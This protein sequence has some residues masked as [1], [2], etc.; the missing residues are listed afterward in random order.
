MFVALWPLPAAARRLG[1]QAR[2]AASRHGGRA[3]PA[4]DLHV[5]LAF[6]GELA[7]AAAIGLAAR[8]RSG[9]HGACPPPDASMV[10]DRIGSFRGA[11]VTWLGPSVPPAWLQ[12]LAMA[13]RD[14]LDGAGVAYDR[15]PFVPHLTIV[16][17]ARAPADGIAPLSSSGWRVA[18]VR[19]A[20]P[21]ESAGPG[22]GRYQI[23]EWL[24]EEAGPL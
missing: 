12:P 6:I 1:E 19:S 22:A 9:L 23:M 8:L 7:P 21:A 3:M 2:E 17:G 13:V 4:A 15:K 11:N 16:R 14:G 5:T 18:L 24:D 10:F 20:K